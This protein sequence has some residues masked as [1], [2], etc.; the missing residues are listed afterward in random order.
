VIDP[1]LHESSPHTRILFFRQGTFSHINDRVAT[2]MREQFPH[3]ELVEIDVLQDVIKQSPTVIWR[4]AATALGTYLRR[5][6]MGDQDF[7]DCY[8]RTPYMFHAI[9][10]LIAERYSHLAQSAL[11]SIQT[12]SLYDAGIAG[13]PNF[14]YTDHTHL[15]NLQYPGADA[16]KL[17]SARWIKL[18]GSIYQSVRMNLV[19]S[20]FVR[21]SLVRDYQCD[22]ARI[23]VVGA[24]PNMDAPTALP[25][26]DNY[27][28]QTIVFIGIDWERKGGPV[29]IEAFR[30]VLR[31]LPNAKLII[32]G[33]SP[34]VPLPNV[35]VLGRVP[36]PQV[37][38]LMLRASVAVLPSFREP[39]GINTIEA[40]MHGIPVVASKIGGLP[41]VVDDHQCGR[42]VPAGDAPALA[43]ALIDLLADP[44]KCKRYGE[45]A[46]EKARSCYAAPVV[47]RKM[48][49]A[50]RGALELEP[51]RLA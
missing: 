14:L 25:D 18:E 50:I 11:F 49:D 42:I 5:V 22:P 39:Q 43:A 47:A 15:A 38:R 1:A 51:A 10:R 48:G 28:N 32:A 6:A 31:T 17:F 46:R 24:A 16:R 37:S 45:A 23:A 44:A 3:L 9:R 2:W 36:L 21:D 20:S 30:E 33:C 27:A 13:L 40:L 26:N 29:L 41:E 12:Q 19:M 35:E 7:R 8:Y 4:G 34:V